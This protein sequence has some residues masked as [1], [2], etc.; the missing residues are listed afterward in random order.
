MA[1]DVVQ[2]LT[3]TPKYLKSKYFYDYKGDELSVNFYP[4]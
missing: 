2:G 3:T 1:K 4:F